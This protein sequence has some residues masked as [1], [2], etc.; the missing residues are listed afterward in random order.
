MLLDTRAANIPLVPW[1]CELA[2]RSGDVVR[3]VA[4]RPHL[5]DAILEVPGAGEVSIDLTLF[6]CERAATV[7]PPGK[8]CCRDRPIH[9][10]KT[11]SGR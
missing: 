10:G 6:T 2:A 1:L 4:A 9:S 5:A 11:G 8:R 3:V 7:R